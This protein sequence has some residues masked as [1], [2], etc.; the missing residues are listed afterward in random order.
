MKKQRNTKGQF[1]KGNQEG[2]RFPNAP[3]GLD[4]EKSIGQIDARKDFN[5]NLTLRTLA[6]SYNA[7]QVA[8]ESAIKLAEQG[9]PD[10]LIKLLGLAKEPEAQNINLNGGVEVQK[11]FIDAKT[12]KSTD[13]HIDDF[14]NDK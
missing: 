8:Y 7:T 12:K 14:L 2:N 9:K 6:Q 5:V 10:P 13:E 11:V 1:V 4:E 3:Q